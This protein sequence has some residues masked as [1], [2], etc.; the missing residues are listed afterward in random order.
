MDSYQ[1][2][3]N[4]DRKLIEV[5]AAGELSVEDGKKLITLA[6]KAA[7]ENGY[8]ILYD[9]RKGFT[10]VS[11]HEW[12]YLPRDLDVLI[13]PQTL[14]IKAAVLISPTDVVEEYKFYEVVADNVGLR[15]RFFFE[16][17]NALAWLNGEGSAGD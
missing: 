8:N 13:N 7:G 10:K 4:D 1:I 5:E 9:I 3:I 16:E 14:H 15:V 17:N 11:F 12:F 6:R 2:T